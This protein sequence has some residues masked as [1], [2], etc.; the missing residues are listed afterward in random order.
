MTPFLFIV[1]CTLL[2]HFHQCNLFQTNHVITAPQTNLS[3]RPIASESHRAEPSVTLCHPGQA[4]VIP[5]PVAQPRPGNPI[6]GR[7]RSGLG[8]CNESQGESDLQV[9]PARDRDPG[10]A[11]SGAASNSL[12]GNILRAW[13]RWGWAHPSPL[14]R[15]LGL[16][17]R[18]RCAVD[19]D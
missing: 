5:R 3:R 8:C 9:G 10:R 12:V 1:Q 18:I 16:G 2:S 6:P 7:R 15:R 14:R 4:W 11:W 19:S 17:F 13:D